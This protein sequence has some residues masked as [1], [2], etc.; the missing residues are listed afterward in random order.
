MR[1][2]FTFIELLI[3]I[4]IIGIL[5]AIGS[6]SF[7]EFSRRQQV[8][9]AARQVKADLRLAQTEAFA[10]QKPAGCTGDLRAIFFRRLNNTTYS[11][12]ADCSGIGSLI[13]IKTVTM[14]PN[15]T[16][17]AFSPSPPGGSIQFKSVADGT[18]LAGDITLT[19]RGSSVSYIQNVIVKASGDIQ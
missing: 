8:S 5:L 7:R 14:P 17:D 1:R 10:G 15:T 11:I 3:S 9:G 6:V 2:G 19:I 13:N 12:D 4:T 18:N 16:L